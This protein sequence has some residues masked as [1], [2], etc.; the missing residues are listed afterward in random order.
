MFKYCQFCLY[1]TSNGGCCNEIFDVDNKGRMFYT[2]CADGNRF[3]PAFPKESVTEMMAR[4]NTLYGDDPEQCHRSMD[5][6]MCD[7]LKYYGY[8]DAIKIFKDADKWYV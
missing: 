2:S 8:E 3:T 5:N 6:L 4:F 1:H 7:I